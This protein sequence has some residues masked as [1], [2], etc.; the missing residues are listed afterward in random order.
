MTSLRLTLLISISLFIPFVSAYGQE[1]AVSRFG[2]LN[3]KTDETGHIKYRLFF[4]NK[5]ILE[6]EGHSLELKE[7]LKGNNRDF[8]IVVENSGG[9]ACPSQV[10]IAELNKAGEV[11]TS[12]EFGCLPPEKTRLV[13][14]KVV[15]EI[16]P[17]VPHPELRTKRD[18]RK[19]ERTKEVYTW[20]KGRLS[21]KIVPRYQHSK[22]T[23]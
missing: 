8:V 1:K 4:R 5:Q 20:D 6:Y 12:E 13:N 23:R 19:A 3:V 17:Y 2:K 14:D 10:V 18:L 11:K 7:V 16:N 22:V 15:I 9:I 21:K